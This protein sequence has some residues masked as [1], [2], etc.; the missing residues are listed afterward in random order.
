MGRRVHQVS[1][2]SVLALAACGPGLDAVVSV[3]PLD[4]GDVC[5]TG[6][7]QVASGQD[8]DRDGTLDADEVTHTE[9]VCA[10]EEGEAGAPGEDGADGADGQDGAPASAMLIEATPL[11]PGDT[12]GAGGVL[13]RF[14]AD[15]DA[16][17]V[18]DDDE[19]TATSTVC[20][21]EDGTSVNIAT[22]AIAPGAECPGGGTRVLA[23]HDDDGD[24]A[25]DADEVES[26]RAVCNGTDGTDG[27]DGADGTSYAA[28]TVLYGDYTIANNLDAALLAGVEV[29][30][31]TLRVMSDVMP[32]VRLDDLQRVDGSLTVTG[33]TLERLVF[34]GLTTVGGTVELRGNPRL[35]SLA[36]LS[37]LTYAG[38]LRVDDNDALTSFV[39]LGPTLAT[40]SAV[41]VDND[42]VTTLAGLEGLTAP[43][44]VTITRSGALVSLSGLGVTETAYLGVNANPALTSLDGLA[45][46]VRA[47]N[48]GIVE[49]PLLVSLSG[50]EGVTSADQVSVYG[51]T[52]LT[53]LEG[54]GLTSVNYLEVSENPALTSLRGLERLTSVDSVYIAS[55]ASLA[56]LSALGGGLLTTLAGDVVISANPLL[57]DLSG[58]DRVTHAGALVIADNERLGSTHGLDALTNVGL[59][60][61][62]GNATLTRFDALAGVRRVEASTYIVDNG[63]CVPSDIA[64]TLRTA[65]LGGATFGC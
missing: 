18:L 2:L 62:S 22:E 25:L 60:W 16:D 23:G 13:V 19:V 15:S 33:S 14:G 54:L 39:G 61:I 28:G 20:D 44:Y 64:A 50:L 40:Q 36:G 29:I 30:T 31:G 21:G 4:P 1:I 47:D 45:G 56:S 42:G 43:E 5:A 59:L 12:C 9:A 35:T 37:A 34:P 7:V 3:V 48:V 38:R 32:E 55:N 26:S 11:P 17:G 27:A 65:S 8:R 58:L 63:G 6:G 49:N 41:I 52:A 53:S 10:G 24:G 51:N 57:T 46:M